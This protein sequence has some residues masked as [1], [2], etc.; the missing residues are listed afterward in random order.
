[1]CFDLLLD[2]RLKKG[3]K[4]YFFFFKLVSQSCRKVK[5]WKVMKCQGETKKFRKPLL[6]KTL[7]ILQVEVS[8]IN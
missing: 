3:E 6:E 2:S 4:D 5:L 7:K 8:R 1:M